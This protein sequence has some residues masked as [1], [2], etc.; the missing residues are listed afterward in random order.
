MFSNLRQGNLVYIIDKQNKLSVSIGQIVETNAIDF[1]KGYLPVNGNTLINITVNIEGVERK[2]GNVPGAQSV[3]SYDNGTTIIADN[4][5]IAT[6]EVR[7]II[8][9][10]QIR[11]DNREYDERIIASGDEAL[12]KLNPQYDKEKKQEEDIANINKRIY[13]MTNKFDKLITALSKYENEKPK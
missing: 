8:K 3:I 10:S 13:D 9:Q 1:N 7:N 6:A 11:L 2:F 5:D 4:V 12:R